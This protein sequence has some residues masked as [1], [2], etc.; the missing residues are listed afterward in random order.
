MKR[1][2]QS[3]KGLSHTNDSNFDHGRGYYIQCAVDSGNQS[4][5]CEW[6]LG[7]VVMEEGSS[8][9]ETVKISSGVQGQQGVWVYLAALFTSTSVSFHV[10]TDAENIVSNTLPLV[11][12]DDG[13]IEDPSS[14]PLVC[15]LFPRL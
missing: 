8:T 14:S 2:H 7:F 4:G 10:I 9:P 6:E 3:C 1:I 12:V 13:N 5:P 11:N 15:F